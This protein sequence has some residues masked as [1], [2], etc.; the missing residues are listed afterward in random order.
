MNFLRRLPPRAELILISLICF[1][2]F[3]ATSIA[4]L[5]RQ[6]TIL[7]YDDRRLYT[8]VAIEVVASMFAIAILRARGWKLSD[9]NLRPSMLQL[10][11][12]M[13]LFIGANVTIASF[14]TVFRAVTGTDPAL[15]TTPVA[16]ATWPA[17]ILLCL[18]DPL[19]EET[20]E[21]A[22]ILRA[23]ERDGPAFGITLSATIRLICHLYQGPIAPLTILPLGIIFAVVYWRTRR[24]WPL[25]IAHGVAGWFA[26]APG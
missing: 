13:V 5:M 19:Y 9:F 15:A 10:I 6:E 20:F 22:Y 12:G 14:Y 24:V 8:I 1:G 23:T 7:L 2:P 18:I 16:R 4:G 21:V 3:A 17:L 25:A 11:A 26:L